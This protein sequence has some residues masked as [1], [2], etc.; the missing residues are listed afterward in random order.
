VISVA[1]VAIQTNER[2]GKRFSYSVWRVARTAL[3]VYLLVVL[4]LMILERWLVYPAPPI[5]R[6][7]WHPAG[8][9]H[10]DVHFQS[11]DGTK[12]HGWFVPHSNARRAILYCHGNA[13]QVGDLADLLA[14]L[15]DTLQASIFVF[16]YRGYG[17]SEGRPDEAGCIADGRAAQHWLAKRVGVKPSQIVLLG[18]SLGGG[19]AV[20]LAADDGA[21]A[22]V[23]ENTFP[24]LV[25]VA[26][27]H[28]P[29]LPVRWLMDNRYDSLS[30]IQ[31]YSGPL[32]QIHGTLDDLIPPSFGRQLFDASPS[33]DK[34]FREIP[35][36]G[37]NDSWP[38]SYYVELAR[39]L[40][41]VGA[42]TAVATG[43]PINSPQ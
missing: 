23:L 43:E 14:H 42:Q 18:R 1:S 24:A 2:D 33:R 7:D 30:R 9:V 37:H 8:L 16:D 36:R 6:G 41:Q 22:L 25:D 3:V 19:V 34:Q 4:V 35:D 15:R 5:E 26:A 28:F 38:S 40:D 10:E 32:F 29:W 31:R 21:Q 13:E 27:R 17:H 12:L 20:A 39:F 11:A